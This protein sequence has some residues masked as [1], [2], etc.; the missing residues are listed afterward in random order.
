MIKKRLHAP[1]THGLQTFIQ[2]FDPLKQRLGALCLSF[3]EALL[4]AAMVWKTVDSL[5]KTGKR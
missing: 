4:W 3:P 5:E 1:C 2:N